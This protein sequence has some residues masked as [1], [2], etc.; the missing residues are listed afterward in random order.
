MPNKRRD[1]PGKLLEER[2]I[3]PRPDDKPAPPVPPKEPERSKQAPDI[4]N[5]S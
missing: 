1:T 3:P 4:G 5:S 2:S